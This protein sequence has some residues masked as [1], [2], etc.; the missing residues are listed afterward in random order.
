MIVRR[1]K[2]NIR[3]KDVGFMMSFGPADVR[4]FLKDF[5]NSCSTDDVEFF[6]GLSFKESDLRY[7]SEHDPF[8]FAAFES[9]W[10]E[11]LSAWLWYQW[12]EAGYFVK[13]ASQDEVFYFSEKAL[14]LVGKKSRKK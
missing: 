4:R 14:A 12:L 7:W 8:V 3:A 5:F 11:Q 9:P 13:S 2:L 10:R 6:R 1:N